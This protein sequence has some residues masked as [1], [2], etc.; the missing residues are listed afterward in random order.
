MRV[1]TSPIQGTGGRRACS[2]GSSPNLLL[3]TNKSS[4]SSSK[5]VQS[6]HSKESSIGGG[7]KS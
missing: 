1:F 2:T 5:G 3:S 6:T 7:N 4:S